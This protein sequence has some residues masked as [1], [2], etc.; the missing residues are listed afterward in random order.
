MMRVTASLVRRYLSHVARRRDVAARRRMQPPSS[1]PT[2]DPLR[3][4][5]AADM[6]RAG[7]PLSLLA[8]R[9]AHERKGDIAMLPFAGADDVDSDPQPRAT[10]TACAWPATRSSTRVSAARTR[11][12]L[13]N[14]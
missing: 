13:E 8:G 11:E 3:T 9:G 7:R 12:W 10:P 4:D 5:W 2:A 1:P 14:P 6:R